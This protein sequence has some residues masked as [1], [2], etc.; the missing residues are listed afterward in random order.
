MSFVP[1]SLCFAAAA[2]VLNIWLGVRIGQIRH[3]RK[4]SLG[5]GNDPLLYARMRAQANFIEN[6]PLTLALFALVELAS[7]RGGPWGGWMLPVLGAVFIIGRI[8]HAFGMDG[9]FKAGR[10]IG[11]LSA[12]ATGL[13]LAV[14]AVL[15]V[16]GKH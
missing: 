13:T 11:T 3:A 6:T 16:A 15:I 12:Y 14:V 9:K 8:A 4:I 1:N 7:P 5:D 2:I 10:G